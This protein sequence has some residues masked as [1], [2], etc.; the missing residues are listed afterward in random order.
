MNK[1]LENKKGERVMFLGNEAI[2][3][4]AL[5]SGVQFVSTY[6]GTPAS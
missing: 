4:G 1:L 2:I 6:P 3:R 5:E